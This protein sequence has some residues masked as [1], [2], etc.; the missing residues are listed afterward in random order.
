M[1]SVKVKVEQILSNAPDVKELELKRSLLCL[2]LACTLKLQLL[3]MTV[4]VKELF[5]MRKINVKTVKEKESLKFP[6]FFRLQLNL[7]F[8]MKMISFLLEKQTSIQELWLEIFISE[9]SSI[10]ILN[11]KEK[12]QIFIT[13]RK[14]HCYSR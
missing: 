13:R 8:L 3:V 14:Y 11:L 4:M 10:L 6:K 12:V 5:L 1:R 9:C 7:E 2:D